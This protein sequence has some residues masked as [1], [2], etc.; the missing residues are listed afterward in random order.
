[1]IYQE[2]GTMIKDGNGSFAIIISTVNFIDCHILF[3][4]RDVTNGK[5]NRLEYW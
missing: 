2:I 5:I 4:V 3:N 1:M